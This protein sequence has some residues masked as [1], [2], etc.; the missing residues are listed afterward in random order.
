M[1]CFGDFLGLSV[2]LKEKH[3]RIDKTIVKSRKSTKWEIMLTVVLKEN[4]FA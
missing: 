1:A 3:V 4:L 2:R